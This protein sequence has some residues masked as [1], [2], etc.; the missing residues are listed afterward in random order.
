VKSTAPD[1]ELSGN[2]CCSDAASHT[3][4]LVLREAIP[5]GFA[6]FDW[7]FPQSA[8][9]FARLIC[10]TRVETEA[11]ISRKRS[12]GRNGRRSGKRFRTKSGVEA[13]EKDSRSGGRKRLAS[14][15]VLARG[16]L[17]QTK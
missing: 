11:C 13:F 7:V 2:Q 16:N 6:G 8:Q 17:P 10:D 4:T 12:S 9:R 1:V 3:A 14:G 15:F 5:S